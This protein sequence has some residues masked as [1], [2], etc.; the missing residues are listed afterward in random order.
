MNEPDE[1]VMPRQV[2]FFY[3]LNKRKRRVNNDISV[4]YT[5]FTN[6]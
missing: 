5:L 2:C 1:R 3:N 4:F 6:A